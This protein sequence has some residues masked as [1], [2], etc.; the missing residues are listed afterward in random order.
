MD[1]ACTSSS[2]VS[3]ETCTHP[4]IYMHVAYTHMHV[5]GFSA[6]YLGELGLCI[7][8]RNRVLCLRVVK[9]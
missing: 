7:F 6:K 5:V 2:D 8:K 9:P 4:R 1:V 3:L